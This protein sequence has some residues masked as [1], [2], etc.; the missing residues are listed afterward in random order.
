[1][2]WFLALVVVL[3]GIVVAIALGAYVG[4]CIQRRLNLDLLPEDRE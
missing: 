2:I 4:G 3:V 1:M